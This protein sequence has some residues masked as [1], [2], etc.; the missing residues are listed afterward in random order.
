M[1]VDYTGWTTD[2]KMFDSSIQR[3]QKA[4]FP[5]N[6]VIPG[7]TE[8][9]G[10]MNVGDKYKFYIPPALGYGEGGTP[11]GPIGPNQALVFEVELLGIQQGEAPAEAVE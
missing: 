2:G 8:G 4:T 5:L 1:T 9:V 6:G 10:L 11:G 3:G 7:W